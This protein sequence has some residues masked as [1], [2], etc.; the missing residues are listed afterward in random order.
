MDIDGQLIPNI[1]FGM[2]Y[3]YVVGQQSANEKLVII[4]DKARPK[5]VKPNES[6]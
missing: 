2:S 3:V 4:S 1:I 6:V 5:S